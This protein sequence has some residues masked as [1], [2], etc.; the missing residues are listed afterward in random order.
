MELN[1][2]FVP[3]EK[4]KGV[5]KILV[6]GDLHFAARSIMILDVVKKEVL[7]QI[8]KKDPDLV[9]FLG[10][11]LDRFGSLD[12][13]RNEEAYDFF[14]EVTLTHRILLLIGNHDI[15]NKTYF[16][17]GSHGF[18]GMRYYWENTTVVDKKCVELEINGHIFQA[19]PYCPNGMLDKGL[20][21]L[22][23]RSKKPSAIFC[24]QEI[25]GCNLR[26]RIV[27]KEGD[28]W[29]KDAPLL[30]C[31]HI[32]K[33]H[34]PQENVWYTG[35]PYQDNFGEDY[36]DKSISYIIFDGDTVTE[37]RIK[38]QVPIKRQLLMAAKKYSEWEP[39]EG[40]IYRIEVTG[41][42]K[43]NSKLRLINKTIKIKD[44]GGKVSFKNV[45]TFDRSRFSNNFYNEK[46]RVLKEVIIESIKDKTH[47]QPIFKQV[48][49]EVYDP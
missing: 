20:N 36:A 49:D 32:H 5:A 6:V 19:V 43:E 41:S 46:K 8:K 14:Y 2:E 22:P 44:D 31:G 25:M 42:S 29:P 38:L 26:P 35:S 3:E 24:H 30:I 16:M 47:L 34:H 15:P 1:N 45:D 12:S 39:E 9:V 7:E 33:Y 13:T 18:V 23:D 10:D 17:C 40:N 4:K 28:I 27:S 48:F 11:T 21:T 37:E